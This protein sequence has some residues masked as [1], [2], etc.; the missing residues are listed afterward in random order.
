MDFIQQLM[1]SSTFTW[2]I[3]PILIFLSR[4]CDVSIGTLRIIYVSRS[5][6]FLAPLL[7]F[8]EVSIWLVAISQIMQNLDNIVCFIGYAGGF[9][10][11]NFIG[12]LIEEKLAVGTLMIR[13][14]QSSETGI[15]ERLYTAGF[16]V[17]SIDAHGKNGAVEII[18]TIIKRKDL[19]KVVRI[20]E[21]CQANTFYSIEDAKSVKKGIFPSSKKS[22]I[23]PAR[24][25]RNR[26]LSRKGK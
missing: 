25:F 26:R 11:G 10:M 22:W 5:K 20:I 14:F 3:L 4:I 21:A 13:I 19:D 8:F 7:G 23:T 15:K 17:T 9:A 18:F 16:G 1:D 24:L 12:I 6:K 2:V